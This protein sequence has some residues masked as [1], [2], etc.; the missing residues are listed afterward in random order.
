MKLEYE[1]DNDARSD[2][3]SNPE[4]LSLGFILI[5][6]PI[7]NDAQLNLN[8]LCSIISILKKIDKITKG[9][10]ALQV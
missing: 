8:Y 5:G 10:Q 6:R 9:N 1:C 7:N 4:L 2:Q 3:K